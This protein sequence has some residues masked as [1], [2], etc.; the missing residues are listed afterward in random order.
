MEDEAAFANL[1]DEISAFGLGPAYGDVIHA[2]YYGSFRA[3]AKTRDWIHGW[4]L[5]RLLLDEAVLP[6]K[7][8]RVF[9]VVGDSLA[10]FHLLFDDSGFH[11]RHIAESDG[12]FPQAVTFYLLEIWRRDALLAASCSTTTKRL[13]R[14]QSK[15]KME[16]W[17]WL[18]NTLWTASGDIEFLK[19]IS[20]RCVKTAE[21]RRLVWGYHDMHCNNVIIEEEQRVDLGDDDDDDKNGYGTSKSDE[22]K[23]KVRLKR[24][25]ENGPKS[26]QF[27]QADFSGPAF[28]VFDL[29]SILVSFEDVRL[30]QERTG[31]IGFTS[32]VRSDAIRWIVEGY[33]RRIQAADSKNAEN[34]AP[35]EELTPKLIHDAWVFAPLAAIM[36]AFDLFYDACDADDEVDEDEEE[37]PS[38]ASAVDNILQ[39]A[40]NHLIIYSHTLKKLERALKAHRHYLTKQKKTALN[41]K[42]R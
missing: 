2:T 15:E 35:I 8:E 1:V 5:K 23:M 39:A 3:V 11:E 41:L 24:L 32:D 31:A 16:E 26:V 12:S 19:G 29:A 30:R 4:S 14:M 27:G 20:V 40:K 38:G 9:N 36:K 6:H 22:E 37:H 17:D 13:E 25:Y 7:L 18:F 42:I 10:R 34:H 21:A 28:A 33:L